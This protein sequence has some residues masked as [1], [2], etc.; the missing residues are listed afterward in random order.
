MQKLLLQEQDREKHR[1]LLT[2]QLNEIR[3]C[4]LKVGEDEELADEKKI[5]KSSDTL[6]ELGRLSYDILT[7]TIVDNLNQVRKNIELMAQDD[8]SLNETL[9]RIASSSYELDDL[10]RQLHQYLQ[11]IPSDPIRLE[12]IEARIDL[13]QKLKRKYGGPRTL[14]EGVIRFAE[15]AAEELAAL[16]TMDL[17]LA[18]TEKKLAGLE[19]ELLQRAESLSEARKKKTEK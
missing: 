13:L 16:D 18:D 2:F 11:N 10:T 12:E 14:L 1:D 7:D 5:L 17:Q 3:A 8:K 15:Q 4:A 9:A 6:L 19:K